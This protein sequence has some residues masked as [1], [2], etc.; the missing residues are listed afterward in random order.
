[1]ERVLELY[2]CHSGVHHVNFRDNKLYELNGGEKGSAAMYR[3]DR[4]LEIVGNS[5]DGIIISK[6]QCV[7]SRCSIPRNILTLK[8]IHHWCAKGRADTEHTKTQNSVHIKPHYCN[9]H[10][11]FFR[12]A[13]DSRS[14]EY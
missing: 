13:P 2:L 3:D 5:S 4:Q 6:S 1:M 14:G 10:A 9:R 7:R 8:D 11:S 12:S